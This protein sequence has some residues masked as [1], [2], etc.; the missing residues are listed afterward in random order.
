[1]FSHKQLKRHKKH[2]PMIVTHLYQKLITFVDNINQK[3]VSWAR[4]IFTSELVLWVQVHCQQSVAPSWGECK[5]LQTEG[6][7]TA[8]ILRNL[9]VFSKH[10]AQQINR[11][12]T[13]RACRAERHPLLHQL[14]A[15]QTK[16]QQWGLELVMCVRAGLPI[17]WLFSSE[18][19]PCE[20]KH[21]FYYLWG[22]P[23][24]FIML[25]LLCHMPSTNPPFQRG[26]SS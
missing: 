5:T 12:S 1:M 3:D 26:F 4:S 18:K 2:F 10:K 19:L 15:C 9:L 11:I 16:Q 25:V 8:A 23:L 13:M 21:S 22:Q 24:L 20:E 17:P 14:V 7:N 6:R